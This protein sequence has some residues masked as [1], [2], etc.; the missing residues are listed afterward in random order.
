M[1]TQILGYS[2]GIRTKLIT[3]EKGITI[4]L[5]FHGPYTREDKDAPNLEV[6]LNPVFVRNNHVICDHGC[7]V[8]IDHAYAG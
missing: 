7:A 1:D 3:V 5:F 4:D 2:L 6:C 8:R